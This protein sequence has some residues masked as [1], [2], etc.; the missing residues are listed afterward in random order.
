MS[1]AQA[2]QL[3]C[4]VCSVGSSRNRVLLRCGSDD[5]SDGPWFHPDCIG[6]AIISRNVKNAQ[7]WLCPWCVLKQPSLLSER[8][9]L[10]L[11]LQTS[12]LDSL[13]SQTKSSAP[14]YHAHVDVA[15]RSHPSEYGL[16]TSSASFTSK[17]VLSPPLS[18]A[19]YLKKKRSTTACCD[20]P[21]VI[22]N[23]DDNSRTCAKCRRECAIICN[24]TVSFN[25]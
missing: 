10:A 12:R 1:A 5:C 9:L 2:P 15:V 23:T 7:N 6:S 22:S 25:M 24:H 13:R 8:Q 18:S 14:I 19:T 4:S 16:A 21:V 3:S 20:S 11:T 17:E